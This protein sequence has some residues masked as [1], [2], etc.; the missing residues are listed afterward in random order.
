MQ[1]TPL[2]FQRTV[3]GVEG[4]APMSQIMKRQTAVYGSHRGDLPIPRRP[5]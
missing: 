1:Q 3:Y 4:G 5:S 2:D